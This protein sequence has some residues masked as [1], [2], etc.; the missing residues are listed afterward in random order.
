[1]SART[2]NVDDI[3]WFDFETKSGEDLQAAGATRY[4]CDPDAAAIILAYAIGRGPVRLVTAPVPG[5]ALTWDDLPDDF[6]AFYANLEQYPSSDVSKFAAFNA[7]FDRAIWNYTLP[8]APWLYPDMVIDPSVQ[9][10]AAGLPPDLDSA[11]MMSG[12]IPKLA[13][14]DDL[15]RLFC[16]PGATATPQSHPKE[17]A[18]FRTY[19]A[20]DIAAMRSLFLRTRQLPLRE[21]EEYWAME[22]IN[23]R[24][25]IVDVEFARKADALAQVAKVRNGLELRELTGGAVTSVG[26]V[27]PLTQWLLTQMPE[28]GDGTKLLTKREAEEVSEDGEAVIVPAKYSLTRSRVERLIPYCKAIGAEAAERALQI[29]LYGGSTTPA[30][31]ARILRQEVDG[32]IYGQYVFNG[33][34]QTGRAS[35]RGVQVQNLSRSYLP[36][37]H[38]AIEA[39]VEGAD[40]DEFA[41][42]G[43]NT[44]VARKLALLI[45]PAFVSRGTNQFVV[46]DFSQIEARVLPWLVGPKSSGALDRL[47]I[48]EAVD[49]DPTTPDLYTRTAAE[50]SGLRIGTPLSTVTKAMRQRGKVAELALGFGGGVGALA[51]MGANYGL[52]LPEAEAKEVVGRWRTANAW[53]VRFWGRHDENAS[54][55]LWGAANRALE[56]PGT[57]QTAGRITYVYVRQAL[58]G[59][60]YCQLPSGRCLAYRGIKYERV[61]ELDDDNKVIGHSTQLRF[62]KGRNRATVWHGT[63]CEN[64]VQATAADILRGTL[65]ELVDSGFAVRL[66][67]HDEVLVECADADAPGVAEALRQYMRQGFH[68]TEGLPLMSEETI[69]P[70]YSKWES[71]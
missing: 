43:D 17:W 11:C 58:G 66:H 63:L 10:T 42:L 41:E 48:F 50:I 27:K 23:D 28:D 31:Y 33:A 37:E 12:S 56:Q 18:A 70:Y 53:C 9:A 47:E 69:Q 59:T 39:I 49:A 4:A 54:Y 61:T 44:P 1:M 51:S 34:P 36:Y 13:D 15:I 55:G 57:E 26:Q 25:I 32:T 22:A 5:E 65:V 30:K 2:F 71:K 14:G 38:D 7:G 68:W 52:Y 46:S 16:V 24:G 6:R 60:L 20:G 8:G 64:V 3:C 19:A 40:Y 35:S 67:S 45:R 62:W 29:R 21:W